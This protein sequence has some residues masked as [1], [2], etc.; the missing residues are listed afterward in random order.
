MKKINVLG[1][2]LLLI[3]VLLASCSTTNQNTIKVGS[4]DFTENIIISEIY[5]LALEQE[6][7][8]V[9]RVQNIA[10]SI[11]HTAI[12]NGEIDMYPEYTGTGLLT[13]LKM[14]LITDP[15]VVYETVKKEY[16]EQFGLTWL[17]YADVNDSAGL[18]IRKDVA[19]KYNIKT[20]SDLQKNAENIRFASQGEFDLRDDGLPLLKK[21][22]GDFKWKS[23][24]VY[25]NGL[26]YEVLRNNEADLAP[27]YTTEG[28]LVETE[29]FQLVEDDK[30]VWP[31]YNIAPVVRNEIL[32][33]NPGIADILNNISK[34]LDNKTV[35]ELNAKVDIEKLEYQNVAK[36]FFDSIRKG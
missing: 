29:M 1:S 14:D 21:V 10:S 2:V 27:A 36:D 9:E 13:I 26:K 24:K 31:P 16:N 6:G 7:Y 12:V 8:T 30:K 20:I 19:Q 22:Y 3:G 35:I 5:A 34:K 23:S 17:E 32:E 25:D 4:K 18:V 11:T 15:E 33:K 28:Q